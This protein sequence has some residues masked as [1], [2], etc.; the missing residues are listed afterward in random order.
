MSKGALRTKGDAA[1]AANTGDRSTVAASFI[2]FQQLEGYRPDNVTTG[3]NL[4]S[5]ALSTLIGDGS[6]LIIKVADDINRTYA[7]YRLSPHLQPI[8]EAFAANV[9]GVGFKYPPV[10]DPDKPAD[11]K[12]VRELLEYKKADGDFDADV[13]VSDAE[14]EAELARIRRRIPRERAFLK[15]FFSSCTPDMPF[16]E[17]CLLVGQDLEINGRAYVEVARDVEG[18]PA[19][20]LWAPAWSIRAQPFGPYISIRERVPISDIHWDYKVTL[21]RFRSWV[22][23]NA[24]SSV[25]ARFKQYGD[26][27][28]MSRK[29]GHYYDT[30][31][32]MLE[33]P[34]EYYTHE[35][36]KTGEDREI[37]ALSA[38]ELLEFKLPSAASSTYGKAA[39]TGAYP[40]VE[41]TRDLAEHNKD[42][43]TDQKIPQMVVLVAG[44]RGI[45]EEDIERLKA[46]IKNKKPGERGIYFI[47]AID[48][49]YA[50]TAGQP[51]TTQM[52]VIKTKSEQHTDA[53]GLKYKEDALNELRRMWRIP[54]IALGDGEGITRATALALMRFTEVQVY[55]PRRDLRDTRWNQYLLPDLNIE[56][57]RMRTTS[58]V[59]KEPDELANII[60]TLVQ[61]NVLTPDEAR[62]FAGDIFHKDLRDLRG[63]WSKIPTQLLT[64]LLQTKNQL[65]AA[66]VLGGEDGA[67]DLMQ[68]LE[69]VF[70]TPG[71][72]QGAAPAPPR[73]SVGEPPNDPSKESREEEGAPARQ[74]RGDA[75]SGSGDG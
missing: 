59:P 34:E 53:L 12:K 35:D 75:G 27:R 23:L 62:E 65:I 52:K 40:G 55:D 14:V 32:Q 36:P 67:D 30:Y 8:L 44:N 7:A 58:R 66:A 13:S 33:N 18:R 5:L 19:Q 1:Q 50:A 57:V 47:Q 48:Q 39:W 20:L 16:L 3:D 26:P 49:Q 72:A 37:P 68:R 31:E 17:L 4:E 42:V 15:S 2:P 9:Y 43:V 64:S 38:T 63:R 61:A 51:G 60:K 69:E 25:V 70:R 22:Q 21:K 73:S 45:P 29:T 54:R 56:C 24:H 41:G 10:V 28:T 71:A 11:Q 46:E 6:T 74:G